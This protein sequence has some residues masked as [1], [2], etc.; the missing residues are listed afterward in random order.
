MNWGTRVYPVSYTYDYAG[1]MKTMVTWKDFSGN[2]G[3]ATT[4]W[5]YDPNRGFLTNKTYD[6]GA[7]GPAYMY[8]PAGRLKTRTWARNIM[9]TYS[10]DNAG[11]L[12]TIVYSDGSTPNVTYTPDRLGRRSTSACNGITDTL[13]YD[14][15]NDLL[16]ESYSGGTLNGQAVTNGYDAFL[17]RAASGLSAQPSALTIHGYDNAGRVQSVANG[18]TSVTYTYVANSS[19]IWQITFSS[20]GTARMTT[21]KTYDF[22][23]RLT[24]ISSLNGQGATLDSHGYGYNSANQ[25]TTVTN[26]DSS[27][28]SYQ[29]DSLGQVTNGA[30]YW[31]DG[32][33]VAG[34]QFGYSF[35]TIGN[36]QRTAAGGDQTG[37]NLRFASYT[38]NNLNQYSSRTVPNAADVL[39][40]AT[41]A[42]IV[43][44]NGQATYRKND[45]YR[46]QLGIDNSGGPVFQGITNLAVLSQ[47]A[48]PLLSNTTG[49][50]F[51]PRNPESFTYDADGNLSSDGRWSYTWDAEN[52]LS[53]VVARTTAGPQQSI[54]FEYD[55]TGRRIGKKV[56][57]NTTFGGTPAVEL[58]FLY[59]GWNLIA[60]LNSAFG[61]QTSFIW[62]LD[63]SGSA[64]GAGGV[65]GLLAMNDAVNGVHFPSY[66]ANG[67]VTALT[68]A[69]DGSVP[70]PNMN[71][72]PSV[73]SSA[74]PG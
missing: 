42:A 74:R 57:N 56:W 44:V 68:K 61:L 65:G 43:T 54:T 27:Y 17:R 19:L 2:T 63:V 5:N 50:I 46:L 39:G 7:P 37:S 73:N 22:V 69:I 13:A 24:G 36:R 6:G 51:L 53:T 32:T 34:Q 52:R 23:N 18:T 14:T 4:T 59:D 35:D 1:R 20:G 71:T 58:K 11:G 64:Q 67:N 25:R 38:A 33:P 48:Y 29:Y 49:N 16:S 15:A 9:T 30:K 72:A 28:W 45:Y 10:Y 60:V 55:S 12:S 62:G 3:L 41:N 21:T 31:S 8:T 70:P 66:E 47:R 26:A 40:S